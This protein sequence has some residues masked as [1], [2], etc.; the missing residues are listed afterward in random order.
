MSSIVRTS[1]FTITPA[2]VRSDPSAD[3]PF[4]PHAVRTIQS[5][6]AAVLLSTRL[7]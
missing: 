4:D 3:D 1:I 5:A 7:G 6:R 2:I